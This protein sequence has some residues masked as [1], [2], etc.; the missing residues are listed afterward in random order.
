M[1]M[2]PFAL[3]S[4][5]ARTVVSA[6]EAQVEFPSSKSRQQVEQEALEKAQVDALE[7]AFGRAVIA[8][9][10]TYMKNLSTGKETKTS[11]VFNMMANTWVK[12]EVIE[13]LNTRFDD[14]EG[15]GVVDGKKRKIIEIKCRVEVRARE[16][17]EATPDFETYPV[18]CL[19]AGCRKS[20]FAENEPLYLYFRAASDGFL[21]VFLDDGK[22]AQG[23]LPYQQMPKKYSDGVPV[24]GGKEYIFFSREKAFTYFETAAVTDEIVCQAET[25]LDQNR[26]FVIFSKTPIASP[27]LQ[28]GLK[29]ETLT[30]LE[31]ES[32]Y[33]VPRAM[34]SEPFQQW[35]IN[36]R[37]R[38]QDLRVVPIDITISK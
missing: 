29:A 36:S 1:A 15:T 27:S 5:E 30:A 38:K 9:N 23:L 35:L 19:N 22:I 13:V 18:G 10:S 2:L 24:E 26:L 3:L 7:R 16:L 25:P 17:T 21:S 12:G 4:Q 6:G 14:I 32:G 34:K 37:I 20:A 8:G 28:P 31:K 33:K 11:T